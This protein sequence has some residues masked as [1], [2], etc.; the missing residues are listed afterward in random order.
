MLKEISR[1]FLLKTIFLDPLNWIAK[2]QKGMKKRPTCK[3]SV[4][5][6]TWKY[7]HSCHWVTA[8]P[9]EVHLVMFNVVIFCESLPQVEQLCRET[10][11]HRGRHESMSSAS[12]ANCCAQS[13]V[14]C[15]KVRICEAQGNAWFLHAREII[16]H[17][18]NRFAGCF[19]TNFATRAPKKKQW[20]FSTAFLLFNLVCQGF[21]GNLSATLDLSICDTG[22]HLFHL[23]VW[24]SCLESHS[25][26]C[27]G[28]NKH[29][30][31]RM[32]KGQYSS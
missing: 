17:S 10:D 28:F 27:P 9:V 5:V 32:L 11:E 13:A 6:L 1:W 14:A 22:C 4:C 30:K 19:L 29:W 23:V 15:R 3:V 24:V 7:W 16:C 12:S 8:V 20:T 21:E 2:G 26:A 25:F 18:Q 31:I